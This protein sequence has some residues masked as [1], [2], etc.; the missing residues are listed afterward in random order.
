MPDSESL[1][2]KNHPD[3]RAGYLTAQPIGIYPGKHTQLLTVH[4]KL[5]GNQTA[6]IYLVAA[7][8][9][10]CMRYLFFLTL[11]LAGLTARAASSNALCHRPDLP[12]AISSG[13]EEDRDKKEGE[14][15]TTRPTLFNDRTFT[16]RRSKQSGGAKSLQPSLLERG[17][18]LLFGTATTRRDTAEPVGT[19]FATTIIS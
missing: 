5:L 15:P 17:V 13:G 16:P 8:I 10:E 19:G 11:L 4:T 3:K 12:A 6:T 9:L 7:L 2:L 1:R 14:C 18:K